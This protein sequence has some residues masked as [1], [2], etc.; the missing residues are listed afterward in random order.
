L[1]YIM[2]TLFQKMLLRFEDE[3]AKEEQEKLEEGIVV[4]KNAEAAEQN[5]ETE[6]ENGVKDAG[7]Q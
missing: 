2:G 5:A 4:E 1:F 7:E 6:A 3:I